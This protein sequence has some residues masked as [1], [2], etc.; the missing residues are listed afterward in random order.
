MFAFLKKVKIRLVGNTGLPHRLSQFLGF[1]KLPSVLQIIPFKEEHKVF[2]ISGGVENLVCLF[3]DR[4]AL[5]LVRI[6]DTF[7]LC[8]VFDFMSNQHIRHV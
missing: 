2:G 3:A 5:S 6:E 8:I 1:Y 4:F 7:S